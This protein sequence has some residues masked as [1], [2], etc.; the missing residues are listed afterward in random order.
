M[1]QKASWYRLDHSHTLCAYNCLVENCVPSIPGGFMA[2]AG[3]ASPRKLST[4]YSTWL[5][6]AHRHLLAGWHLFFA[7]G[8]IHPFAAGVPFRHR[9][10]IYKALEAR[11]SGGNRGRLTRKA[12]YSR[13]LPRFASLLHLVGWIACE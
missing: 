5:H 9:H 3:G 1:K 7:P 11:N 10:I 13:G 4:I 2:Y 12:R 6:R 8:Y